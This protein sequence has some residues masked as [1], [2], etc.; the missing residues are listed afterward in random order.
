MV[1]LQFDGV[2]NK[3]NYSLTFGADI[4]GSKSHVAMNAWRPQASSKHVKTQAPF[5][6]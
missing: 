1:S 4:E 6:R 2:A 5:A 3:Y